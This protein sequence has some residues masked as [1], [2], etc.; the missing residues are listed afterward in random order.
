MRKVFYVAGT[1]DLLHW[2]H[3]KFLN[4]VK[5][6][7]DGVNEDLIIALNTDEF[8]ERYKRKPIFKLEER[9]K[10]LEQVGFSV[11][12]INDNN[13]QSEIERRIS[14]LGVTHI[15]HG[16]DWTGE[17]YLRQLGV[18]QKFLDE[19]DITMVYLPYT[20]GISSSEIIKRCQNAKYNL[21]K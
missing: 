8:A 4:R 14:N 6:L 5:E 2:G 15:V 13:N 17:D 10:S 21:D 3:L 16:D 11:I 7:V 12:A 20:K 9:R 18:T 1:F 19:F